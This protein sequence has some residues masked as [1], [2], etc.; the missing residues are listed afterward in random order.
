MVG[1]KG[2]S[3]FLFLV[4]FTIYGS[5]PLVHA[6]YIGNMSSE[7]KPHEPNFI[8]GPIIVK[9]SDSFEINFYTTVAV[10][11]VSIGTVIAVS[12]LKMR[13]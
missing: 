4:L 7:Y 9:N 2:I 1:I 3:T 13:K 8:G 6:Q 11:I 5:S 10:A 12:I